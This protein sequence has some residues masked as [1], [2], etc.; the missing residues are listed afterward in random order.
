[1]TDSTDST[2]STLSPVSEREAEAGLV[3]QLLDQILEKAHPLL[4]EGLYLAAV[5]HEYDVALLKALRVRDDGRDERLAARL[6]RFSFIRRLEGS[7]DEAKQRYAM[8]ATERDHL[9]RRWI[10]ADPQA[11]VVAHRRALAFWETH[12]HPDPFTQDQSRLYHLLLTDSE[13][14]IEYLVDTFRTYTG[15]RRLAA[16]DRLL[17]TAA[18]ARAY[19]AALAVPDLA[20]LDDLLAFLTVRLQQLRGGWQESLP[21]LERLQQKADL[22]PRLVPYVARAYGLALAG[23]GQY[24]EA[25]AQYQ[26]AL[27]AFGRQP[28]GEEEQ[29]LTMINLGDAYVDLAISAR[30]YREIIPSPAGRWRQWL[31]G[32]L[33]FRGLLPLIV[34]LSFHFGLR[35]WRPGFWPMLQD[36]DWIIARLFV[37]GARWY[38][39]ARRLL[40]RLGAHA[41]RVQAD[42]K[43]AHL[44]L[45]IGD[46]AQAAS[47]FQALLEERDAPLGEYR[48]ASVQAGQGW[49]LLRLGRSELARERLQKALPVVQ[50]YDD[51]TLEAQVQSLLAEVL[52][53]TGRHGEALHQFRRALRLYQKQGDIVGATE[54][55]ERLQVLAQDRRLNVTD[56]E[57]AS[58]TTQNLTR[59]HFLGRFQHPALVTFRRV[60]LVLLALFV[61]VIPMLAIHV[62]RGSVVQADIRFHAEPLLELNPDYSPSL[63]QA[64]AL[65]VAPAFE[66]EFLLQRVIELL[67]IYLLAYAVLGIV[68]IARTNL[69][70][71]QAAQSEGVRFDLRALTVGRGGTEQTVPWEEISRVTT[72]DIEFFGGSMADNSLTVVASPQGALTIKGSTAWYTDIQDHV[73]FFASKARVLN[74]GYRILRSRMS[75]LYLLSGLSLVLFLLLRAWAQ[76]AL[77]TDLLGTPYS[78][79]DLY[80]YLYLGLFVPSVWW[81]VIRP[82]QIQRHLNPRSLLVWWVGGG[83]VLLAVLGWVVSGRHWPIVESIFPL[84]PLL[85]VVVL[86]A[87]AGW[88]VWTVR[89]SDAQKQGRGSHVYPLWVRG[90]VA[91]V[92][93]AVLAGVGTQ[94]WREVGSYHFLMVG[95][96]QRDRGLKVQAQ[97]EDAVA[98][99]WLNKAVASYDRVL[100]LL[101]QDVT[102]LGSRAA[103]QAQLGRYEEAIGDYAQV[104][105]HHGADPK[106][107]A[108]RAMAY[109]GWGLTLSESGETEAAEVKFAA[110]LNDFGQAIQLDPENVDYYL[111]RAVVYHAL[112]QLDAALKD[113]ERALELAP[114]NAKALTGRG[115]VLWQTADELSDEAAQ[116]ED[117]VTK[118]ELEA[119]AQQGFELAL[120]S[121]Q[122]A[123]RYDPR[124]PEIWLALGYAHFKLEQNSET[125]NAWVRAMELSPDDPVM[126]V[127]RAT[128]R[129]LVADG[130]RCQS[131]AVSDAE[132][133]EAVYYLNLAKGDLNHVLALRPNDHLTYRIRAQIE[134]L[135]RYCPG[136]TYREQVEKAI[137]GY[138]EA[139]KYDPDNAVYWQY[140]GRLVSVLAR[141]TFLKG[142]EKEAQAWAELA[143]AAADIERAYAL[144]PEDEVTHLWQ[145]YI[146]EEAWA[147]FHQV[148]GWER[149][150]AGEYGLGEADS[151]KAALLMP[152]DAELAF[153]AGLMALAQGK[154]DQA[155]VWYE[156]GLRRAAADPKDSLRM[157]E[158]GMGDLVA[159]LEARPAVRWLGDPILG[160][161]YLQFGEAAL[162]A[163][164]DLLAGA[165]FEQAASL[166]PQDPA[167]AFK[168]GLLSLAQGKSNA[169]GEWYRVGLERAA[170][171]QEA[172]ADMRAVEAAMADLMALVQANPR[173]KWL[174]TPILEELRA[175]AVNASG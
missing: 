58:T 156:E 7:A 35:V 123:A 17:T 134:F 121:F 18:E 159:L 47:S 2:D 113:Y 44:Y 133:E 142:P 126:I 1:M 78:L 101:P 38:R 151:E 32:L 157:L 49:A 4:A 13:A 141:D 39:R 125:L 165:R 29:A 37:T 55:A 10:E 75:L 108:Y 57:T 153:N 30:G 127:S 145:E 31:D 175:A 114:Q 67:L 167:A 93:V 144:D 160:L 85:A 137:A 105:Q 91:A 27:E 28:D 120:E 174:S 140:R 148:R 130:N 6:A 122:Q 21:A 68:L 61:F 98:E 138:D 107:Y 170:A 102:A 152:Q 50:A 161:F 9:S 106:V 16:V 164:D 33:S 162:A 117:E 104:L 155:V 94:L 150:E 65:N 54:I 70:T 43:L 81:I 26:V 60:G 41:G 166:R 14:G 15:E 83:G 149:Y 82:L 73:R 118:V 46:A 42:E 87:G 139:L 128:G 52:L 74:L 132:K 3:A 163:G 24:V 63:G 79:A 158:T 173:L 11:F 20:D 169:A 89:R 103:V 62:E 76:E 72:A 45:R 84:Y 115:W 23:T 5:P 80:P 51:V 171:L 99:W 53:G 168:A 146:A 59:R 77:L 119:A 172:G 95:N 147:R 112:G 131:A 143:I 88:V 34:Y 124:S 109:E 36:Q 8:L 136:H 48:R 64:V 19:M 135:L 40:G 129:W 86:V 69:R 92:A 22:P 90:L 97:G 111:Q 116:A 56:R 71:V 96:S 12:P 66:A 154:T 25:L 110:A 100:A